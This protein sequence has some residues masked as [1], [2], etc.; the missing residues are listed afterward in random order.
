MK[1]AMDYCFS[2]DRD[3]DGLIEN[4]NVGHGWLEGGGNL[5]GF[6]TEF[7]LAGLWKAALDDAAYLSSAIGHDASAL[8]Y[9]RA[10]RSVDGPLEKFWN[11][12]KGWY[13]YA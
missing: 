7:Y 3:G 10:S 5:W 12:D 8:R 6:R 4:S 11:E 9:R 1:L 2:T 13:N